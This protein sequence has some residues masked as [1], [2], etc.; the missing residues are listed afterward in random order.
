[1]FLRNVLFPWSSESSGMYCR[2][3]NWMLTDV[4][5]VHAASIIRVM[6]D[7]DRGSTYLWNVGRH[8]IKNMAVHPRR[9][10]ASCLP[11]WE[12]EISHTFSIFRAEV[13]ILR[14]EGIYIGSEE[15]KLEEVGQSETTTS[16]AFRFS[17][18]P[19]LLLH[20]WRWETL[21]SSTVLASTYESTQCQ[22]SE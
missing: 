16:T 4:L 5:E 18:P 22:H 12:L 15:G 20:P 1:M 6:S 17:N 10:W 7:D 9:F 14:N 11:L 8:S 2:V 3:L 21:C 13:V 19:A